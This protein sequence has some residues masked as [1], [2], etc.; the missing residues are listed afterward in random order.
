[1]KLVG[2]SWAFICRPFIQKA[3]LLGIIAAISASALLFFGIHSLKQ[4]EPDI[5]TVI[6]YQTLAIV[7]ASVFCFGIL[8]TTL[9]TYVSLR[10]YLRMSSNELYHI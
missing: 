7:A 2:A 5:T 4:Y 3:L 1:M 10:R 6:T 8:I 9:C